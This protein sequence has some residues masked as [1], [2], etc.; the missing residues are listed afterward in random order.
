MYV[1]I[2]FGNARIQSPTGS[3]SAELAVDFSVYVSTNPCCAVFMN[4]HI[5][6]YIY[7]CAREYVRVCRLNVVLTNAKKQQILL[8]FNA[9]N[10]PPPSQQQQFAASEQQTL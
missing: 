2:V 7:G 10:L 3:Y 4:T 1:C 5:H 8:L 9:N 6:T